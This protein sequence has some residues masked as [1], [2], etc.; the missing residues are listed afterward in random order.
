M[1]TARA[2][3]LFQSDNE[4]EMTMNSHG[5]ANAQKWAWACLWWLNMHFIQICSSQ[6]L[7]TSYL[8]HE[9]LMILHYVQHALVILYISHFMAYRCH[10]NV[11][12]V[13][14]VVSTI[15]V[16]EHVSINSVQ[17]VLICWLW[18]RFEG[19][20]LVLKGERQSPLMLNLHAG[21][22]CGATRV[23]L[24][25]LR[26][27]VKILEGYLAPSVR[28][29]CLWLCSAM[30]LCGSYLMNDIVCTPGLSILPKILTFLQ[31]LLD[32]DTSHICYS[33]M[34]AAISA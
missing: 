15:D 32:S 29:L 18:C 6:A 13:H 28:S 11:P 26:K 14:Q 9:N 4:P 12:F 20:E 27:L 34:W 22:T 10:W 5:L 33:C 17:S 3:S 19:A 8:R 7:M 30:S 21:K 23:Q 31:E 1:S 2:R 24:M 25:A 16:A